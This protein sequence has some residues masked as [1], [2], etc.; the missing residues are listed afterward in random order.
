VAIK[1]LGRGIESEAAVRA[2]RAERHVLTRLEHP[3]IVRLL[4]SGTTEDG[5]RI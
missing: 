1:L 3:N 5:A 2:F 4:D